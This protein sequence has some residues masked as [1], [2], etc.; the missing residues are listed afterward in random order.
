MVGSGGEPAAGANNRRLVIINLLVVVASFAFALFTRDQYPD[1]YPA[2]YNFAGEVTRYASSDSSEWLAMPFVA[3]GLFVIMAGVVWLIWKV[4]PSLMN[5]PEKDKF[6]ALSDEQRAPI[7]VAIARVIWVYTLLQ[8]CACLALQDLMLQSARGGSKLVAI[9][10][11]VV[12]GT[13]AIIEFTLGTLRIRRMIR[14]ATAGS[15]AA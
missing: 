11:L 10:A 2:H 14:A 8:T 5:V 1:R 15:G 12:I 3:L 9:L 13:I 7:L 4:P 6:V